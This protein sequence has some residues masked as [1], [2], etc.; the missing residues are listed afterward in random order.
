MR[1][2]KTPI[3]VDITDAAALWSDDRSRTSHSAQELSWASFDTSIQSMAT[4]LKKRLK[5]D[6]VVGVVHGGVFVG[7]ALAAALDCPFFSV[8][9]ARRSRDAGFATPRALSVMPPL[10]GRVVVVADDIASSGD[11]LSLGSRLAKKAGAKKVATAA[12]VQRSAGFSADFV[13]QISDRFFVFPW[14]Y[15][16]VALDARFEVQKTGGAPKPATRNKK[17]KKR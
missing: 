8:R 10:K 1:K 6:V 4:A 9:I 16:A 2:A 15:A 13:G 17:R 7:S 14:D 11:A 5:P 12:L 3:K